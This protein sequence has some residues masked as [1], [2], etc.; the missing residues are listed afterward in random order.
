MGDPY[1]DFDGDNDLSNIQVNIFCVKGP[2]RTMSVS[3]RETFLHSDVTIF[4]PKDPQNPSIPTIKLQKHKIVKDKI[5]LSDS[6]EVLLNKIA[7]HCCKE[8]ITGKDIFAW[9]DHNPKRD[10]SLQYCYPL[11]IKYSDLKKYMNPYVDKDYD[12]RF[13]NVD[14][15]SKRNS[16]Y[17]LDYYSSY[18]SYVD[19]LSSSDS[20]TIYFCSVTTILEYLSGDKVSHKLKERKGDLVMNG[21][22]KKYF[23]LF[24]DGDKDYKTKITTKTEI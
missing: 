22:L 2:L 3:E 8:D 19:I 11:G 13:A 1:L 9:I 18:G 14:G 15:T 24:Q 12:T 10:I 6:I 16:K 17:S 23:P 5:Y 7:I 20:Y 21:Y 4:N